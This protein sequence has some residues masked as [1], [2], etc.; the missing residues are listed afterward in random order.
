MVNDVAS[1]HLAKPDSIYTGLALIVPRVWRVLRAKLYEERISIQPH[2]RRVHCLGAGEVG[3]FVI[4]L[5]ITYYD[6]YGSPTVIA[7]AIYS[8]LTATLR[9]L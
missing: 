4:S 5:Q 8:S 3:R 2:P 1:L 7:R 6:K 9:R